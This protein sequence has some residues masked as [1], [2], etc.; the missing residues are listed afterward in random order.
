MSE[1]S[2]TKKNVRVKNLRL[3]SYPQVRQVEKPVKNGNC[4]STPEVVERLIDGFRSVD[5]INK[6]SACAKTQD[7][8]ISFV[9]NGKWIKAA[10]KLCVRTVTSD[11]G[12]SG[13]KPS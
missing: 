2:R 6:N 1:C 7:E 12:G 5:L 10:G 3:S 8:C 9:E 4:Y 13:F 11:K